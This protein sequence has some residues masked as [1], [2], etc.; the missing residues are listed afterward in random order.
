MTE[1]MCPVLRVA[2]SNHPVK[3]ERVKRSGAT[4]RM[5][6]ILHYT[7]PVNKDVASLVIYVSSYYVIYIFHSVTHTW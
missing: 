7:Q 5:T 1:C 3:G 6:P 2:R 4:Y